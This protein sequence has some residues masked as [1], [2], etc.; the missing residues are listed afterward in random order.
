MADLPSSGPV[1]IQAGFITITGTE[2][3]FNGEAYVVGG[4]LHFQIAG[5]FVI[6]CNQFHVIQHGAGVP[7]D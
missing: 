7:T 2:M 1:T 5:D 6:E 3:N 4:N